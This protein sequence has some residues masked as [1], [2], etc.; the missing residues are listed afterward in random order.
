MYIYINN[1]YNNHN[2]HNKH[3]NDITDNESHFLYKKDKNSTILNQGLDY[4]SNK[5]NKFNKI[6]SIFS[7]SVKEGFNFRGILGSNTNMNAK[8]ERDKNNINNMTYGLNSRISDYNISRNNLRKK[9]IEYLDNSND[10][11]T[12]RN[13]NMFINSIPNPSISSYNACVDTTS[14]N[15]NMAPDTNFNTAYPLITDADGNQQSNFS[16]FADAKEACKTWAIDSNKTVFALSKDQTNDKQYNC[17]VGDNPSTALYTRAT[18]AYELVD[19]S[20]DGAN[21][22]GLFKNGL[23]GVYTSNDTSTTTQTKDFSYL[24]ENLLKTPKPYKIA[25]FGVST[26]NIWYRSGWEDN[27]KQNGNTFP[28]R[29][30]QWIWDNANNYGLTKN[31]YY[32]YTNNS[33]SDIQAKLHIMVDNYINKFVFNGVEDT[34]L[35]NQRDY[36][37]IKNITLIPGLNVFHFV[38]GN[39]GYHRGAVI[40]LIKDSDNTILFNS[41]N[42][43]TSNWAIH[44]REL[45]YNKIVSNNTDGGLETLKIKYYDDYSHGIE[46]ISPYSSCDE[47]NGG[48]II[49]STIQASFGRNCSNISLEPKYARYVMVKNRPYARAS[50]LHGGSWLQI[51][52]LDIYGYVGGQL[53]NLSLKAKQPGGAGE[54]IAIIMEEIGLG[55]L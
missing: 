9:Q 12:R 18:K 34:T 8:I 42:N 39:S 7:P 3:H 30:A 22:G 2:N 6:T 11:I 49:G 32:F 19:G 13:F 4:M 17:H 50:V 53:Q 33:G 40:S 35:I 23:I 44:E 45:D 24:L 21:R 47:F 51:G 55:S 15:V 1:M 14:L 36:V 37:P 38:F 27:K 26:N 5:F 48:Q 25:Q 29:S 31:M 41:T 10:T 43:N 16:T 54:V 28:D 20:S 52:D 46:K